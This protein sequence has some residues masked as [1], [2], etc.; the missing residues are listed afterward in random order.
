MRCR[1]AARAQEVHQSWQ[2]AFVLREVVGV[3]RVSE[4]RVKQLAG[5]SGRFMAR[6][7]GRLS[8]TRART[9]KRSAFAAYTADFAEPEEVAL[10]LHEKVCRARRNARVASKGWQG[11]EET[12][13]ERAGR[14]LSFSRTAR[15]S[16]Q[17]RAA[18]SIQERVP[19]KLLLYN[20]NTLEEKQGG[21]QCIA[22][23]PSVIRVTTRLVATH[24]ANLDLATEQPQ[25]TT[26]VGRIS[27]SVAS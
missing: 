24:L 6:Q 1:L 9:S 11:T 14:R 22:V 20:L 18:R 21:Y 16:W 2:E 15:T 27:A 23:L 26:V 8:P 10:A 12:S 5:T 4:S 3:V 7:A 19:L 13:P 17:V 25:G